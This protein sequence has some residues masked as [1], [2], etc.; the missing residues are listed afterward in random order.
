MDFSDFAWRD[1]LLGALAL[2]GI[3]LT[4]ALLGLARLRR[5]RQAAPSF[6]MPKDLFAPTIETNIEPTIGPAIRPTMGPTL[7]T[8]APAARFAASEPVTIDDFWPPSTSSPSSPDS[9]ALPP[10]PASAPS[11]AEPSPVS[12]AVQLAATE[13]EAELAAEVK[14]LRA[15]VEALREE[16]A[17]LKA[18]RRVS[19]LYADAAALAQRGYDARGVAEECGIS[20]AEA[21]L[22]M[23]MS[24]DDANFDKEL[25]EVNNGEPGRPVA[26]NAARR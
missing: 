10:T 19:P 15:D 9:S 21:E 12:F 13:R 20:V 1:V 25:D 17:E 4:V 11:H 8:Q 16:L 26:A 2:A 22:V 14:Q 23:A 7:D 5:G 18:A 3:Y 6:E 24:R